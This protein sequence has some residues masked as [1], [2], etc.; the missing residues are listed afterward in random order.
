MQNCEDKSQNSQ[1]FRFFNLFSK[2]HQTNS[3]FSSQQFVIKIESN[4]YER[5]RERERERES[6]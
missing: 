4:G 5:E 3:K 6:T 1:S 2:P